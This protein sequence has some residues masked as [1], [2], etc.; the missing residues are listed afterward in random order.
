MIY[1]LLLGAYVCYNVSNFKGNNFLFKSYQHFFD[2]ISLLKVQKGQKRGNYNV[3]SLSAIVAF[4][5]LVTWL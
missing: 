5:L 1:T 3:F 2:F 4:C